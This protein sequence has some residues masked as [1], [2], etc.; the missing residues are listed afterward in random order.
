MWGCLRGTRGGQLGVYVLPSEWIGRT[1]VLGVWEEEGRDGCV[2]A[3][4]Q[5][6]GGGGVDTVGGAV[7][8]AV[9]SSHLDFECVEAGV[10]AGKL[11][12]GR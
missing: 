2:D 7:G 9:G 4:L 12:R 10:R 8:N 5:G 6:T 1:K 3:R 11:L